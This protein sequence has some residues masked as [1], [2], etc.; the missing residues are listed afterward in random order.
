MGVSNRG[1]E[2]ARPLIDRPR[3]LA[4]PGWSLA[5][6]SATLLWGAT[7]HTLMSLRV[8]VLGGWSPGPLPF[9]RHEFSDRCV[10]FE[11][12]MHMPPAG[13]R[14]CCTWEAALL[15]IDIFLISYASARA[16][17]GW[18]YVALLVAGL[19]APLPLIVLL[20]RGSIRRSAATAR[21]AIARHNIDIVVGF[22]WGGGIACWL[23]HAGSW[24]GPT[25]MLAPTLSAMSSVS[26]ASVTH[27][28]FDVADASSRLRPAKPDDSDES[29]AGDSASSVHIFHAT[30]DGFCPHSQIE[31][32]AR[33]GAAMHLCTDAHPLDEPRTLREI[34]E[35]FGE[36]IRVAESR[37]Q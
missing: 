31:A 2:Y 24:A 12:A 22:S 7:P 30:H 14:W 16:H 28:F 9:L 20:V 35:A 32:L 27:P 8:L 26:C 1:V 17:V 4:L 25:L 34:G 21:R 29:S 10:F 5:P 11:P 15:A 33:T 18:Y 6:S 19:L 3:R 36:L 37:R 23:H 13:A